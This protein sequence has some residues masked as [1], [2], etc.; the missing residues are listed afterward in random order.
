MAIVKLNPGFS[1]PRGAVGNLV[2]KHYGDKVVLTRKPRFENRVFSAAQ[3]ATQQ[4]FR[5][6]MWDAKT[7][8]ADPLIRSRYEQIA[9]EKGKPILSVMVADLLRQPGTIQ[10][11]T[12]DTNNG[13]L[14]TEESKVAVF[15]LLTNATTR[16]RR[17]KRA[18]P[19]WNRLKPC[20]PS[21]HPGKGLRQTGLTK[22][23]PAADLHVKPTLKRH[24]K[25]PCQ[26]HDFRDC[27]KNPELPRPSERV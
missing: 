9:R 7:A 10:P 22:G 3:L 16:R 13:L 14:K 18:V 27:V 8:L 4:R 24:L 15:D 5:R 2:F 19:M 23:R 25:F 21:L 17:E 11:A 1:A 26:A 20:R 12:D 6:A